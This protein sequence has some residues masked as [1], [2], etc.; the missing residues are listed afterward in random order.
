MAL[1]KP[2]Q[3]SPQDSTIDATLENRFS[4]QTNGGVQTGYRV[5]IYNNDTGVLAHDTTQV[6]SP[7]EYYDLP[8]S[9]LSNGQD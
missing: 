4:W 1:F 9:T 7:N 8:A 2:N 6:S 5:Y 3:L